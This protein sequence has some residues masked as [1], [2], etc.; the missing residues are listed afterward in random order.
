[1]NEEPS[2]SMLAW[3][4]I[5]PSFW[6]YVVEKFLRNCEFQPLSHSLLEMILKCK[7]MVKLG[8]QRKVFIESLSSKKDFINFFTQ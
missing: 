3:F 7:H 1:M 2:P 8:M 4:L 6:T 5:M